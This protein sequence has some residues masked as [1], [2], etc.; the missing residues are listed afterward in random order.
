M[1]IG[2]DP[3][4]A[5]Q[6]LSKL[7][8]EA[9]RLHLSLWEVHILEHLGW[10]ATLVGQ[11]TFAQERFRAS[12]EIISRVGLPASAVRQM[13][14]SA[15]ALQEG[16]LEHAEQLVAE[17]VNMLRGGAP[18][19]LAMVRANMLL[20]RIALERGEYQRA[21]DHLDRGVQVQRE[22]GGY[23]DSSAFL[24]E[25]LELLVRA[26]LALGQPD[27]AGVRSAE[28]RTLAKQMD[29][30]YLTALASR[31]AALVLASSGDSERAARELA[32]CASAWER[33]GWPYEVARTLQDLG[34]VYQTA[35]SQEKARESY[36]R[37]VEL[38]RSM[39]AI[40]VADGLLARL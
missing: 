37:A 35:G 32:E 7:L 3:G 20:G 9:R 39:G 27:A 8:D 12:A 38:F 23:V 15:L 2:G 21:I 30:P 18:R 28:L 1:F 26:L 29:E 34:R 19:H 31:A 6:E 25:L 4:E 11:L 16:D 33:L 14:R 10:I 17:A 13:F 24:A 36:A 40:G 22:R 5:D